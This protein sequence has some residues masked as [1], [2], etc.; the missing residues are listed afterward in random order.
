MDDS[1]YRRSPPDGSDIVPPP[2]ARWQH[3]RQYISITIPWVGFNIYRSH[4][5]PWLGPEDKLESL[6]ATRRVT[7]RLWGKVWPLARVNQTQ[8]EN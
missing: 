3:W 4:Y 5:P 1:E 7:T 2:T 6:H 8:V